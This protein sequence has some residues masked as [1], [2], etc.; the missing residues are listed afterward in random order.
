[1]N[2][3]KVGKSRKQFSF[4]CD[5]W[6]RVNKIRVKESTYVKYN[7]IVEKRIK[8]SLGEY[9]VNYLSTSSVENFTQELYAE[10]LQPKTVKDILIVLNS[11]FKYS[12]RQY[13]GMFKNIEV[14][15]P[16]NAK[17][18]MRVLTKDEQMRFVNYLLADTDSCKFGTLLALL[19]GIRIG[20][21]CALRAENISVKEGI[22]KVTSTMQRLKNFDESANKKT[23]IVIT[24]PKSDTSVRI[25]PLSGFTL[26]LCKKHI[27][28][29]PNAFILS[30]SSAKIVE[31]RTLQYKM[32][33]YCREC[34]L[35]A[36]HF[37]TLRHTFATRCVEV[38]FEIKSLSEILGH[39]SPQITLER[40]VH[41]SLELKRDNMNKLSIV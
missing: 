33:K 30:G 5:E 8:P 23:K 3:P 7:A 18:E 27:P 20:E 22:I 29:V 24:E 37:H 39:S 40:Y 16:K 38:G 28:T 10:E 6:L 17:K 25:I 31:P 41:S 35:E 12:A 32:E 14:Y 21:L 2:I 15:Y 11:I 13:Q 26:E 34:G 19:T 36:V 1:M 4:Y 9:S